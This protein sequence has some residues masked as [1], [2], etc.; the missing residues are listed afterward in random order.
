[1]TDRASLTAEYMALFRAL[2]TARP[3]SSRWFVDH[4][5]R[6]FLTGW[7]K[8]LYRTSKMPL[9]RRAAESLLVDGTSK[10]TMSPVYRY[11]PEGFTD[12]SHV[13]TPEDFA[14]QIF[15]QVALLFNP[16]HHKR[17]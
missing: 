11:I 5:V 16:E 9:G 6:L 1:M 15:E 3:S 14:A 10:N 17:F 8:W 2:E 4:D 7:R 12:G 13:F